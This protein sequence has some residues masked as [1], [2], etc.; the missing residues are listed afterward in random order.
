MQ[1][2]RDASPLECQVEHDT[3]FDFAYRIVGRV[4]EE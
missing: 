1:L 3:V 4:H 2:A